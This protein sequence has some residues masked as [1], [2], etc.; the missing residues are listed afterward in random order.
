MSL[1]VRQGRPVRK[2]EVW[3]RQAAEENAVYNPT[4]GSVFLLNETALAIWDLCDGETSP[5][6]MV[7]AVVELTGMHPDVVTEDVERILGEFEEA[8]L[9]TW[10]E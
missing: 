2:P 4:T 9:L 5:D 6:E 8:G 3:L 1:T 7:T 10:E